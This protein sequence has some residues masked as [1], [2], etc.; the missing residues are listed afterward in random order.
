[1]KLVFYTPVNQGGVL[2]CER[3]DITYQEKNSLN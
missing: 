3:D 1:M 2:K